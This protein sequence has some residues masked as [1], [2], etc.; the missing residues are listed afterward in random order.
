MKTPAEKAADALL[1]KR[2]PDHMIHDAFEEPK[3]GDAMVGVALHEWPDFSDDAPVTGCIPS[4]QNGFSV[5]LEDDYGNAVHGLMVDDDGVIR[6]YPNSAIDLNG[7]TLRYTAPANCITPTDERHDKA[8]LSRWL[9]VW[10]IGQQ[11]MDLRTTIGRE[12]R[13]MV[14]KKLLDVLADIEAVAK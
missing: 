10:C 2:P 8:E 4:L 12:T 7:V 6:I 13:A 11:P 3:L 9:R 5:R 14:E 1:G